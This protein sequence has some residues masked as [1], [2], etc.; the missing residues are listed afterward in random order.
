MFNANS[1]LQLMEIYNHMPCACIT[2]DVKGKIVNANDTFLKYTGYDR[3]QILNSLNI[4][5]FLPPEN[6]NHICHLVGFRNDQTD[7]SDISYVSLITKDHKR[8]FSN[9]SSLKLNTDTDIYYYYFFIACNRLVISDSDKAILDEQTQVKIA[10]Q[11]SVKLTLELQKVTQTIA[12]DIQNPL[13]NILGLI[14]IFRKRYISSFDSSGLVFLDHIANSGEKM[15]HHFNALLKNYTNGNSIID[16]K[17]V[18]L[19]KII[20]D[21][22]LQLNDQIIKNKVQINIPQPLPSLYG[23]EDQLYRL[24]TNL[25]KNAIQFKEEN[26]SPIINITYMEEES[27]YHFTIEDNG[28]G[29]DKTFHDKIFEDYYK[30]NSDEDECIGRGLPESRKIVVNHKG[31]IGVVSN[32]NKGC[33]IYFSL[34]K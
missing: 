3:D 20:Q 8:V 22:K 21:V 6:Y 16:K 4:E 5:D 27:F 17:L 9:I 34:E 23:I 10:E 11:R 26:N 1:P 31:N 7:D 33:T 14:T 28:I 2:V 24:F 13:K 18:D 19:N 30:V 29:I 12:H 25:L 32:S 15:Q